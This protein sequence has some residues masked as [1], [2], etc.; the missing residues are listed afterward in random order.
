[1]NDDGPGSGRI[2]MSGDA[3]VAVA[4]MLRAGTSTRYETSSSGALCDDDIQ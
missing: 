4:A 3:A 1:M 2:V